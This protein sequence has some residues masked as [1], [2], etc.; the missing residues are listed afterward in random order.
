[1]ITSIEYDT[2]DEVIDSIVELGNKET[3]LLDLLLENLGS[4]LNDSIDNKGDSFILQCIP[5]KK[6]YIYLLDFFIKKGCDVNRKFDSSPIEFWI[7]CSGDLEFLK[8]AI[9]NHGAVL[10][11]EDMRNFA[12]SYNLDEETVNYFDPLVLLDIAIEEDNMELIKLIRPK[13]T[14]N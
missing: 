13:L 8:W 3:T 4:R 7:D 11:Q 5:P 10:S 14:S 2:I 6:E 9:V 1:M 12:G